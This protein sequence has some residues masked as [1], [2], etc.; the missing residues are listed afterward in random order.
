MLFVLKTECLHKQIMF[1]LYFQLKCRNMQEAF[2]FLKGELSKENKNNQKHPIIL[3]INKMQLWGRRGGGKGI[4][5]K[6]NLKQPE[7]E[8]KAFHFV[9]IHS[10][11]SATLITLIVS[12]LDF[13]C[14]FFLGRKVLKCT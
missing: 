12:V 11:L 2:K 6:Q 1:C 4:R 8:F 9:V 7:P 5:Q 3:F 13:S 10:D 14:F